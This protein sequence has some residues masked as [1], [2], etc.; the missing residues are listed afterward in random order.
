MT[1]LFIIV[2]LFG[3]F[4]FPKYIMIFLIIG[5]FTLAGYKMYTDKQAEAE[6][7]AKKEKA[8]ADAMARAMQELREYEASQANKLEEISE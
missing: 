6:A 2:L 4:F 7:Q 5:A 1:A 3:A 8:E